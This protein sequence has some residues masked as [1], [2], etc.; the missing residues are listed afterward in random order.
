MTHG[1]GLNSKALLQQKYFPEN[2]DLFFYGSIA[3]IF[4]FKALYFAII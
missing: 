1:K 3:L 2:F 4:F